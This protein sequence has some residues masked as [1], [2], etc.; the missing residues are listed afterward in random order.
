MIK[1]SSEVQAALKNKQPVLALESTILAH[2]MPWPEN[3]AFAR[4]A[5]ALAR[6]DGVVPATIA[7]FDGIVRVGLN[8]AQLE[9]LCRRKDFDKAGVRD[10]AIVMA[11]KRSA[12][13]TVSATLRI[14][15]R[16]GIAVFSTGGV[17]GV[18]RNVNDSFD[19]SQDLTELSR[20]SGIVISAGAKAI[21]DIGKTLE[22]METLDIPVLG[23]QTDEFPAFYSR[24]SGFPVPARVDSVETI[25]AVFNKRQELSLPGAVLVANPVPASNEIPLDAMAPVIE[26][27]VLEAMNLRLSGKAVTPF[28]LKKIVA[29]TEGQSLKTNIALALNNIRL[30]ADISAVLSR[31]N[32]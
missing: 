2:G 20:T 22:M 19:I 31:S 32:D 13:T 30:G 28:L 7:V 8:D 12:A 10:L 1:L 25:V 9:A 11:Q 5:E 6:T 26:K 16:V 3:L 27:A 17:G 15:N 29:F 21:L 23:Y 18:H 24:S 14:A 4:E